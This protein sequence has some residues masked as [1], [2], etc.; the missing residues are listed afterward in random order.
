MSNRPLKHPDPFLEVRAERLDLAPSLT[1]WCA[2]YEMGEWRCK[3]LAK[4]LL[5]WL[6]EFALKYSEW[7]NLDAHNAVQLMGKAAASI[8]KSKEY[9]RRGEFGEILLHA[10]IRQRFKSIPAISKYYYKDNN[11]DTIKGFDA[12]HV[13]GEGSDWELWLGEV[14]FYN[15]IYKAISDV[16]TEL[17]EHMERDYLR[18]EFSAITNKLDNSWGE[19]AKLRDLLHQNTSLDKIFKSVCI[20]VLLTYDST[21][22]MAHNSVCEEYENAFKEEVFRYRD[23]F[24]S[25]ELPKNVIVRLFLLPLKDKAD[26]VKQMD[27]ALKACQE[28][29]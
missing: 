2:G 9:E 25:K 4:H 15:N 23:L 11:N 3:Q 6:P 27:E 7:S 21:A 20:P 13:V 18:A 24:A 14:K 26:L 16:V 12:V 10:M 29:F 1:A 8:Y 19:A 22:V 28:I 17:Q 5:H